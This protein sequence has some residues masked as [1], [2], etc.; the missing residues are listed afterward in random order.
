M[1]SI[2][3][4][5]NVIVKW[6]LADEDDVD[7]ALEIRD[8]IALGRAEAATPRH[9]LLEVADSLRKAARQGRFVES[10]VVPAL[11]TVDAFGLSVELEAD[12]L[13][14][15]IETALHAHVSVYDA[16]FVQLAADLGAPLVTADRR[17]FEAATAAGSDVVWLADLPSEQHTPR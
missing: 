10:D 16:T 13:V 9:A 17:L 11:R 4:D 2:V 15:A 5:S 3:L 8:Q 6:F 14:R 12:A 1:A 7:R